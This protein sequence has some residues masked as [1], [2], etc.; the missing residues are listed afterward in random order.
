MAV[1]CRFCC[2]S[3]FSLPNS[4]CLS[5]S[6]PLSVYLPL[7]L[8]PA[9]SLSLSLC[10]SVLSSLQLSRSRFLKLSK[11][12]FSGLKPC[13]TS[14]RAT[15]RLQGKKQ[16]DGK[17]EGQNFSGCADRSYAAASSVAADDDELSVKVMTTSFPVASAVF[18]CWLGQSV[19]EVS[20]I[21][22]RNRSRGLLGK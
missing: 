9:L 12:S 11:R 14:L 16:F 2:L 17:G 18:I 13:P 22:K 5:F 1:S 10:N 21:W 8:S 4:L 19:S 20:A 7:S 3:A 6:L 15:C